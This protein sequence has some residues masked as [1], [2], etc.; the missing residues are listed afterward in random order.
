MAGNFSVFINKSR[1]N[2]SAKRPATFWLMLLVGSHNPDDPTE[3]RTSQHINT[4]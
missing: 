3:L 4:L 1:N 2:E